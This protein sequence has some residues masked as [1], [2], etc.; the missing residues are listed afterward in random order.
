MAKTD[1]ERY[2]DALAAVQTGATIEQGMGAGSNEPER[3][4]A[5]LN[6]ATAAV[7]VLTRLL[8]AKAVITQAELDKALA[9]DTEDEVVQYETRI[10]ARNLAFGVSCGCAVCQIT[11]HH[12]PLKLK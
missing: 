8:V 7:G 12:P 6:A 10:N 11:G 5:D 1:R 9:D 4:R 2:D 3:L